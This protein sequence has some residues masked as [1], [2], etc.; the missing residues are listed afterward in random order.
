MFSPN[1]SSAQF[2]LL[3]PQNAIAAKRKTRRAAFNSRN[4]ELLCQLLKNRLVQSNPTFE[5]FERKILVRRMRAAI[6]QRQTHEQSFHSQ[7]AA[8]LRDDWNA[9]ALANHRD[10]CIE[11]LTQGALRRFPDRGMWVG[12]IPR[13]TMSVDDFE[14]DTF[15]QIFLQMRSG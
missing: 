15:R 11:R 4:F 2:A 10:I 6:R 13:T 7:D 3:V 9:S 12:Q 1:D 5:I 8:E 14:R